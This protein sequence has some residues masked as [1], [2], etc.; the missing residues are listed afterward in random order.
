VLRPLNAIP[1]KLPPTLSRP[2]LELTALDYFQRRGDENRGGL[3]RVYEWGEKETKTSSSASTVDYRIIAEKTVLG[4]SIRD[5]EDAI[6]VCAFVSDPYIIP[7]HN[8]AWMSG[9]FRSNRHVGSGLNA[10][11]EPPYPTEPF[12]APET[13]HST[14]FL[15]KMMASISP[16]EKPTRK[17]SISPCVNAK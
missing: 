5:V 17:W 6:I 3:C 2:D 11:G 7:S 12:R 16:G 9:R 8:L 1:K 15:R 14:P 4:M 13:L 10:G